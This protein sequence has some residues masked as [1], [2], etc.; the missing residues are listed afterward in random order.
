MGGCKPTASRVKCVLAITASPGDGD[1]PLP[2]DIEVL[3]PGPES[4]LLLDGVLN[5]KTKKVAPNRL[6]E[7][8]TC[9]CIKTLL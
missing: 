8:R 2:E 3:F 6:N 5:V 9:F 7:C 4:P 1:S